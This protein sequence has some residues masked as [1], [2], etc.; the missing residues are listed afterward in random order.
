[1]VK[2]TSMT[3]STPQGLSGQLDYVGYYAFNYAPSALPPP[4]S[5]WVCPYAWSRMKTTN[6]CPSSK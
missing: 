6:S 1:M 4:L 5:R 2:R 3:V